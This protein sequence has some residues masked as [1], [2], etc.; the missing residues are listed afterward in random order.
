MHLIYIDDS[1]DRPTHVFSGLA[2]PYQHWNDAFGFLKKWREHLRDIHGIPVSY[3]LHA[4]NFLT[5]RGS[6]G[7]LSHL[8]RHTRSQIFHKH[9]QV[10]EYTKKWNARVFNVCHSGDDQ[11]R[12]F[13]RLLNRVNRTMEAWDSYAI[14]ICDEGK[15]TQYTR[16][17]RRMRRHNPIPSNRQFWDDGNITKNITIDRILED[18]YF[19]PSHS[20]Y[21]IQAS[22]FTAHGLLRRE[23]QTP[24]AKRQRI[25][26]SF[27]QLSDVLVPACNLNDAK[28][29]IR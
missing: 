15:E 26:K 4:T 25:H 11:F 28:G 14:L 17:V 5:G 6:R 20:S 22:D 24:R 16:L 18:P 8:S 3:E 23:V 12:A 10:I 27:D 1:S 9:F 2:I 19:K 13:E 29:V 7:T 21:F